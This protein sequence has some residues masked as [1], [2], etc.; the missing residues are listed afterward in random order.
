[1]RNR[2]NFVAIIPARGGS[3]G[4]PQKNIIPLLGK[5]LIYYTIQAALQ[6][7]KLDSIYVST[8]DE[9][10][11]EVAQSYGIKVINRP[12][13]LATSIA[14][15]ES[16]LIHAVNEIKKKNGLVNNIVLL[17]PT[18]PLRTSEDI[19]KAISMFLKRKAD[20]LFSAARFNG[21]LW[22]TKSGKARPIN[23]NFHNRPRRQKIMQYLEN[24]AIYITKADILLKEGCRL[25]GR[26]VIYEMP[27]ERSVEIDTPFDIYLTIEILKRGKNEEDKDWK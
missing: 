12:K 6:T 5:P 10:I 23:Y 1:M 26:I 25:G 17:Q 15:T 19:D 4:I 21:F 3:K 11:K 13:R 20:S 2:Q 7:K 16:V 9:K 27:S 18:S 22:K 24:G 14:T 8:E